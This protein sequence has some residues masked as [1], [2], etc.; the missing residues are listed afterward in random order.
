MLLSPW[1]TNSDFDDFFSPI[2]YRTP[3]WISKRTQDWAVDTFK[4]D[5]VDTPDKYQVQ[6]EI[7][8]RTKE[9]IKIKI[10]N[11]HLTISA[12]SSAEERKEED[13]FIYAEI[14]RGLMCRTVPLPE[15]VDEDSVKATYENGVL[16]V[17]LPKTGKSSR[18]ISIM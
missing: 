15:N 1:K 13:T 11:G 17:L 6:A 4:I 12:E 2:V 10:D 9:N 16:H 8:G 14:K 3:S 7:P 5:M 18:E